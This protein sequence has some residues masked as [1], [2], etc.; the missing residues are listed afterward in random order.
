MATRRTS[1]GK[2][3]RDR[4][5]QANAAAK[6]ERRLEKSSAEDDEVTVIPEE[7][8]LSPAQLLTLVEQLH[9]AYDAKQIDFEE[10]E[11]KKA[12]LMARITVD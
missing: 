2:L 12:E 4:A 5:K 10:F 3:Q 7:G 8:E 1:F 11:E 6:R 9:Q